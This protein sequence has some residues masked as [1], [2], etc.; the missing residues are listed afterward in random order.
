MRDFAFIQRSPDTLLVG[1]GPFTRAKTAA[2]GIPSFYINDFFLDRP[3]PWHIPSEWDERPLDSLSKTLGPPSTPSI[4]WKPVGD[5]PFRS[6]F[7]RAQSAIRAGWFEKIVP[8]VFEEGEIDSDGIAPY[9][10]SRLAEVPSEFH[11]YGHQIGDRGMIGA[12]PEILFRNSGERWETM[13]LAGTRTV[14]KA[15]ELLRDPKEQREHRIVVDD[16]TERLRDAGQVEVMPTVVARFG[17]LAHLHTRIHVSTTNSSFDD[18]VR[19][20]HPTAAL[21][22]WPRSERGIRWLREA[23]AA[24]RRE[25]LGA[26]F[27]FDSGD[28]RALCLAAIRN[29]R[30]KG[31]LVRIGAGA[32]ILGESSYE[33]ERAELE[34]KRRQVKA[35]FGLA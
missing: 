16:I 4:S 3:D 7:A 11:L 21:G 20:L 2:P 8:V 35:L 28:G 14:D 13:A 5:E 33:R 17:Q 31:R 19:R 22:A 25:E 26:P 9:L 24:D 12:T 15:D 32:G 6:L 1:W 23:D 27:G 34:G 10:A 18:M 30:W 29:V